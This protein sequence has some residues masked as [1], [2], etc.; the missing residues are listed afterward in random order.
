MPE[1]GGA[2]GC[3]SFSKFYL[4]ALGQVSYDACPAIPPEIVLL[5]RW[6]YF[7]LYAVSAWSR[8]MILPLAIVSTLR[9]VRKLTEEQ[10]IA[11]LFKDPAAA[12]SPIGRLKGLPRSWREMFLLLDLSL[13][14]R[15]YW[16]SGQ[17]AV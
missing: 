17:A 13:K 16:I 6:M 4:A 9:P 10:G 8:T 5:P 12:N 3:N 15:K 11:E 2:E 14:R 7:N 1:V